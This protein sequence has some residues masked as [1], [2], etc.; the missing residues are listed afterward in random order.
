MPHTTA[1]LKEIANR[2]VYWHP[3]G[4]TPSERLLR[5]VDDEGETAALIPVDPK[6]SEDMNRALA[7]AS[8]MTSAG[9]MYSVCESILRWTDRR[10]GKDG[11]PTPLRRQLIAILARAAGRV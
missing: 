4:L 2:S 5:I 11:L 6:E 9:S 3:H 7:T 10:P 1:Q 8:L